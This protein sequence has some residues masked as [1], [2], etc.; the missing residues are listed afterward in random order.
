MNIR[1][2][3]FLTNLMKIREFNCCINIV[4][5]WFYIFNNLI[6]VII[7]TIVCVCFL[8]LRINMVRLVYFYFGDKISVL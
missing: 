7:I 8:L 1:V 5:T 2:L 6:I 4:I 3:K